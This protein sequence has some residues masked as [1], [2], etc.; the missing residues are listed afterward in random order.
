MRIAILSDIHSNL[1]ALTKALEVIDDSG[2]ER[3]YCLGDIVGYG[4]NPNECV[5]LVRSRAA[6]SVMGNHDLAVVDAEQAEFLDAHGRA[7]AEWTRRL[8]SPENHEFLSR[9]PFLE[10]IE[11]ATLVHSAPAEP[12]AWKRIGTLEDAR[13]Q[14]A[15]FDTPLCFIG[16]THV[17]FVCGED[18]RTMEVRRGMKFLVNVGSVGQPRDGEPRLSFGVFDDAVWEYRNMRVEYDIAGSA[19]AIRRAGL[20][21]GL[22]NRLSRGV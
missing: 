7:A 20:P 6:A 9:L 2:V 21:V 15:H 13:P 5:E 11:H 3:I 1:Q 22:A 19:E 16:H 8:L 12:S 14:F 4:A 10:R 17:P 18:L